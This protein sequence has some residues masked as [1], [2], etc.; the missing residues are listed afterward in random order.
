[1]G[2]RLDALRERF[3]DPNPILVRELRSSFR[4]PRFVRTMTTALMVLLLVVLGGGL[5]GSA[6]SVAP[7]EKGRSIFQVFFT[8]AYVLLAAVAPTFGA[9][10]FTTEKEQET[11]ESVLL[12]GLS[13]ERFVLG[14]LLASYVE[15][16][17][18]LVA[19]V[20]ILGV[21]ILFGGVS[22][23]EVL[24]GFAVLL[25]AIAPGISL[26][27]AL[28]SRL[29]STRTAATLALVI[30]A[31]TAYAG[32]GVMAGIESGRSGKFPGTGDGPFAFV[33]D[34]AA[35]ATDL[36]SWLVLFVAPVVA[37]GLATWL[38]V[39]SAI[40][41][42][43]PE[44]EDRVSPFKAWSIATALA[45]LVGYTALLARVPGTGLDE[46]SLGLQV[47]LVPVALF[48]A[49][50]FA[51]EP[52]LPPRSHRSPST[53]RERVLAH[54]GP[55]SLGTAR[56]ASLL[57]T[58]LL[59]APVALFVV[60]AVLVRGEPKALGDGRALVI[61]LVVAIGSLVASLVVLEL[62][63]FVRTLIGGGVASRAAQLGFGVAASL[64]PLM[65]V[66]ILDL[67]AFDHVPERVPWPL[68]V[69]L[70]APGFV[71]AHLERG[72]PPADVLLLAPFLVLH[73][74]LGLA[75]R[76]ATGR[77]VAAARAR[78]DAVRARLEAE[79]ARRRAGEA[80]A[81]ARPV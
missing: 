63:V 38:F 46:A 42:V 17:L 14:K 56:F 45:L 68:R 24:L 65:I 13:P 39:A 33:S 77:R 32:L 1:M 19:S 67:D 74:S 66:P 54:L 3:R 47:A 80:A 59:L 4:T 40:A 51:N 64:L 18:L 61:A 69:S 34:L 44:A 62:G 8:V 23:L 30:A 48:F 41:G 28:S 36:E 60:V 2:A 29:R 35:N 52:P 12:S 57:L 22:P 21:S 75:L 9:S 15:I 58:E 27:V 49:M 81:E 71:A 31:P 5:A 10:A 78:L 55:G 43:R 76:F 6:G 26:G 53:F 25:V 37:A 16:G 72:S 79:V 70:L 11:Y 7:A 73:G 20:P 50:L